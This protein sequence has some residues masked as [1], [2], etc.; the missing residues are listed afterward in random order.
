MPVS[1]NVRSRYE[2]REVL[3]KGGMGVV[4]RAW[5]TLMKRDVALKTILDVQSR[6]AFDLFYKEWGL[7]ASIIHPNIIEIYDIG[8]FEDNG[9]VRPYFVMPLLPG[10]SLAELIRNDSRRLTVERSVDIM[11]QVCRGLQAAHERGLIHRDIKPSNVFVMADDSVKI[12]D[13]GIAFTEA[14]STHTAMRGTLPYMAPE[15]LQLKPPSVLT[16]IFALGAVAYEALTRRRAFGGK[17]DPEISEAVLHSS[18]PPAS[19]VNPAVGQL[20]SQVVHKALAK[21]PW[22]RYSSAR[23]F[24]DTLLRAVHNEP[25]AFFDKARV[26]PRV[27]RASRAYER[28]EYQFATE[29]LDELDGEGYI[30][31]EISMLRNQV[32][33]A[34][35]QV[36]IRQILE[37]A[38]R[39]HEEEEY[40]LALRKID[41]ALQLDPEHA[42]ALDLK[43]QVERKRRARQVEEWSRLA[44]QHLNDNAFSE[45]RAALESLLELQPGD[46]KA[47]EMLA[48]VDRRA[49]DFETRRQEKSR[50][51]D[52][53]V[54]AWEKG[55]V[56]AALVRLDRWA[57]L[58]RELPETDAARELSCQNFYNQV[59]TEDEALR[60]SLDQARRL[61]AEQNFAAALQIC[62]HY[63]AKYP[64]QPLFQALRFDVEERRRKNLSAF[65]AET[66]Q[67]V[68]SEPDPEKRCAI[69]EEASRLYPGEPHFERSVRLARDK[70]NLVSS[71][72]QKARLQ[73]EQGRYSEA[74]ETWEMLRTIHGQYPGLDNEIARAEKRREAASRSEA[75]SAWVERIDKLLELRE[76]EKAAEAAETALV[77]FPN[78]A[79]ILELE[80]LTCNRIATGAEVERMLEAGRAACVAGNH[81]EG[82]KLMRAALD[83]DPSDPVLR[84]TLVD[85]LTERARELGAGSISGSEALIDEVL[86]LDPGNSFALSLR[87]QHADAQ[88]SEFVYW[89]TAQAR[90]LQTAG[91]LE[92]ARAVVQEGLA[93][94]PQEASLLQLAAK[95]QREV[96]ATKRPQPAPSAARP[97]S[98]MPSAVQTPPPSARPPA[99]EA[100][101]MSQVRY[102]DTAAAFSLPSTETPVTPLPEAFSPAGGPPVLPSPEGGVPPVATGLP[103]P[104]TAAPPVTPAPPVERRQMAMWQWVALAVIGVLALAFAAQYIAGVTPRKAAAPAVITVPLS[105]TTTPPGARVVIDGKDRG[106]SGV[107]LELPV[108]VH[109]I[110][111]VLDGYETASQQVS[112]AAH[113]PLAVQIPPLVPLPAGLR[114]TTDA[115]NPD[116]KLDDQ[117]LG[118]AAPDFATDSVASGHHR[119][120][121]NSR[122]GQATIE[123]DSAPATL[124]VIA[125]ALQARNIN[126]VVLSQ[127]GA[128][129][130]LYSSEPLPVSVDN[131]APVTATPDGIEL[132]VL[133]AGS[134]TLS[135]GEGASQRSLAFQSGSAPALTA[136]IE[137]KAAPETGG[138]LVTAGVD[139]ATVLIN[140]KPNRRPTKNG[141]IRIGN[142]KPGDYSIQVVKDG[143]EPPAE[144]K[145]AVKKGEDA[146]LQFQLRPAVRMA[147][148]HVQGAP[149]GAQVLI[150]DNPAGVVQADGAFSAPVN[151]GAHS[152][153][154][155]NGRAQSRPVQRQFAAG[156]T[157]QFSGSELALQLP[158][159]VLRVHVSPAGAHVTIRGETE[160]ESAARALTQESLTLPE[161]TYVVSATAPDYNP[162]SKTVTVSS[163][164][165]A[166]VDITLI[167]KVKKPAAV[168]GMNRW[169]DAKGWTQEGAWQIHKGGNFLSFQS[170]EVN[171][172]IEFNA[173]LQK[174]KRLEWF[175]ARKD[176]RNYLLFRLDKKNL[177]VEQMAE[178]KNREIAKT[179]VSFDHEQPVAVRI[180]VSA[181]AVNT[182]FRQ[183]TGGWTNTTPLTNPAGNFDK[184]RFGLHIGGRDEIGINSFTYDPR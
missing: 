125:G 167:A 172:R 154:L 35:R 180:E 142:L 184:G 146:R 147:T 174:G 133:A 3:S 132:P 69:L 46:A 108:G 90:R 183:G 66:D 2:L 151:P 159:G 21:Q 98:V 18:P 34:G 170:E 162:S 19:E 11:N 50:L 96:D 103:L 51:Y 119:L 79:E 92:G 59:R 22:H 141:Q 33:R 83:L 128:H 52:E 62:D 60:N 160:R 97:I 78:D 182:S 131:S 113:S 63:L 102:A 57:F 44:R 111:A 43:N 106:V 5:D 137:Q 165:P 93:Q 91:D 55:E 95:L 49:G 178:G 73:E 115:D 6:A 1:T 168:T 156:Q 100:G 8:E 85:A 129:A 14:G 15:L 81:D 88:R 171:G 82:L 41:E 27:E 20:L 37:S 67:R 169:D 122:Q 65:I 17:T 130:R 70:R 117:A 155:R 110:E 36:S 84:A 104:V 123:F 126:A 61:L 71:V 32:G 10:C 176:D 87:R 4:Y 181:G 26:L 138:V 29:I 68:E 24:G 39:F 109:K 179:P 12:I 145:V 54:R 136:F 144:Q 166:P 42:E 158:Q 99:P 94:W 135:V 140:G 101:E 16:D 127:F 149:A 153:M 40:S 107:S 150:D 7:Q 89:C 163:S 31:P 77:E 175:L 143:F 173:L 116:V 28:G 118:G 58:D 86:Q 121:L 177:V 9:T 114:V 124:P 30:D 80:K 161:G 72:V 76:F 164:A 38:R 152:V 25:I 48:E 120:V 56:S 148:I 112:L 53:A 74:V 157:M 23:E 13:F 134:H 139:G 45:A 75:R 105:V 47:R 64:N